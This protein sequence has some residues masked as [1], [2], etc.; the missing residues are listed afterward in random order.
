MQ[1][2]KPDRQSS[3]NIRNAHNKNN[4]NVHCYNCYHYVNEYSYWQIPKT[5]RWFIFKQS[6][7]VIQNKTRSEI[8]KLFSPTQKTQQSHTQ[9]PTLQQNIT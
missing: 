8:K 2:S 5:N 4:H 1:V 6:K 9:L 7:R 3:I